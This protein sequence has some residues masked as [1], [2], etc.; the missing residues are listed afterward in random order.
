MT[1]TKLPLVVVGTVV[2]VTVVSASK[3]ASN[4]TLEIVTFSP[5]IFLVITTLT[6]VPSEFNK[7]GSLA[8]PN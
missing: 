1:C 2:V 7:I 5:V 6:D 8:F 3:Q 4:S